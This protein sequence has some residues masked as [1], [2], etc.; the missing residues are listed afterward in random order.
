MIYGY[1]YFTY[2]NIASLYHLQDY[3]TK[4]DIVKKRKSY[5]Y[6]GENQ[7]IAT[8]REALYQSLY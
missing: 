6:N 7:V 3:T 4:S 2:F 1:A 8:N 5:Q